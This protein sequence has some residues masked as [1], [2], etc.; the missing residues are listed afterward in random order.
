MSMYHMQNPAS[1]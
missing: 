1:S